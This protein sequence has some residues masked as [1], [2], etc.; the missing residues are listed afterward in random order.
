M[1]AELQQ[2][3]ERIQRLVAAYQQTRLECTRAVAARDRLQA[4]ND[5]L[6]EHI[7][8]IVDRLRV[9]EDATP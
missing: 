6:R 5:E 4:V 8:G 3:E 9:L 7:A 1:Q 2:L